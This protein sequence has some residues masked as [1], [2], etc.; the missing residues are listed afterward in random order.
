MAN[1]KAKNP[2]S[3]PLAG[4]DQAVASAVSPVPE[5]FEDRMRRLENAVA[6][7]HNTGPLEERIV[8][9]VV[10]RILRKPVEA[11]REPTEIVL[12]AARTLLPVPLPPPA[13]L[14]QRD[15]KGPPR[16]HSAMGFLAE[17]RA[18]IAMYFDPRYRLSWVGRLAPLVAVILM[19]FCWWFLSAIPIVGLLLDKVLDVGLILVAYKVLAHEARRYLETVT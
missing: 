3:P 2:T 13:V 7:L 5:S 10:A 12:E 9:R 1:R 4:N 8:E 19:F 11:R 6:E 14:V 17:I 16:P 15:P 18:I